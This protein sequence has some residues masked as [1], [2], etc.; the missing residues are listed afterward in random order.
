ME[1][2]AFPPRTRGYGAPEP[3]E[4]QSAKAER[5]AGITIPDFRPPSPGVHPGYM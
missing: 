3:A 2:P 5:N 1:R 4:A